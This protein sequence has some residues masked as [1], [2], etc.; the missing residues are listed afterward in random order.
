SVMARSSFKP[1][2]SFFRKLALGAV[3]A[4]RVQTVLRSRYGHDCI[5]LENGALDSKIWKDVKRK[6]VRIPDLVCTRCG[7]RVESRA[8]TKP[9]LSMSHS[10][11]D[12]ERRWDFGML[13]EDWVAFPICRGRNEGRANYGKLVKS[14]ALWK[15]RNWVTWVPEGA[16]NVFTVGS[17]KKAKHKPKKE[18]GV[19]EGSEAQVYWPSVFAANRQLIA[20]LLP[21]SD[22]SL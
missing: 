2:S 3:G 13:D 5:E 16:V 17:L 21:T 14:T 1:D 22:R 4:H 12:D 10:Q 19:T 7:R 11:A 18:K 9:E 15:E 20:L 8:K 6:R